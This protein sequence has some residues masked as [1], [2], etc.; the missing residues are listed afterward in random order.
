V[1]ELGEPLEPGRREAG[2][3]KVVAGEAEEPQGDDAEE[4]VAVVEAATGAA[5]RVVAAEVE[6]RDLPRGRIAGDALPAAAVRARAL[7]RKVQ[8]GVLEGSPQPQQHGGLVGGACSGRGC[9]DDDGGEAEEACVG[10]L[11]RAAA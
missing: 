6:R 4:G 3:A 2:A 8:A 1:G 10:V 5:P 11:V 7:G 9:D